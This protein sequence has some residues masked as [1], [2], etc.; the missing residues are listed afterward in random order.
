VVTKSL[1]LPLYYFNL[2][3]ES[4]FRSHQKHR[5]R[6]LGRTPLSKIINDM[7]E[8][9][10]LLL[11]GMELL[12]N[13]K[14]HE[15][16]MIEFVKDTIQILRSVKKSIA[17]V[18]TCTDT[19]T[20]P[21]AYQVSNDNH[22]LFTTQ[23]EVTLPEFQPRVDFLTFF[24]KRDYEWI[25]QCALQT[26]GY[27]IRDLYLICREREMIPLQEQLQ[28]VSLDG[29]GL[30]QMIKLIRKH[31]T[32]MDSNGFDTVKPH[33]LWDK[34]G[35]YHE[36]RKQ[37][38]QLILWPSQR[39]EIFDRFQ[40]SPPKGLLLYGPS[41]C[42]KTFLVNAF[43]SNSPFQ[44]I[45][46]KTHQIYSK[47]LG[48]SERKIRLLFE[49][50]RKSR[51]CILFFDRME[52]LGSKRGWDGE[53][54]DGSS[55][56]QERVLSTLLN[57]MDGVSDLHGVFVIACTTD[58]LQLDDALKRPGRLDIH[59]LID[60]PT[61]PERK[62][63]LA[64]LVHSSR[65]RLSNEELEWVA[66]E[67]KGYTCADLVQLVREAGMF[68]LHESFDCEEIKMKHILESIDSGLDPNGIWK[69]QGVF[70]K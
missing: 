27:S 56:V 1:Q 2:F 14:W 57:E 45:S 6:E 70:M 8:K 60:K 63:I 46:V 36:I 28:I 20:L 13:Y 41:G 23:V 51:P 40:I 69:P 12:S 52:V 54:A 16:D 3:E 44:F 5:G 37:L 9:S 53:E 21:I 58:P 24:L 18:S 67:T 29:G 49:T 32:L 64:T 26:V 50:C 17:I 66:L 25:E 61:S 22:A 30:E 35:G 34:V 4:A 42:G 43:V 39:P 47:Y 55:R 7:P 19:T 62:E 68:A 10:V 48:E 11:D 38:E 33:I 15:F 31:K 59:L 65:L